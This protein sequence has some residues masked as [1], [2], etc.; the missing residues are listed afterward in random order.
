MMLRVSRW[1][2]VEVIFAGEVLSVKVF[3]YTLSEFG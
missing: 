2:L 1:K 3:N